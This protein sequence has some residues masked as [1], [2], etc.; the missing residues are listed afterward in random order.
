MSH[1]SLSRVCC[2]ISDCSDSPLT[3]FG[4]GS[5]L[6]IFTMSSK[7]AILPVENFPREKAAAT[8]SRYRGYNLVHVHVCMYVHSGVL[9]KL[10]PKIS[11]E[12]VS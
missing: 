12:D 9:T 1:G 3:S 6:C 5:V 11:K 4:C 7:S 2:L 10:M 8:E